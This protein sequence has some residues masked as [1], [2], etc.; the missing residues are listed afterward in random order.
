MRLGNYLRVFSALI[1]SLFWHSGASAEDYYWTLGG[2]SET[3][4]SAQQSCAS[5]FQTVSTN[6]NNAHESLY[7]FQLAISPAS[8]SG[9]QPR[10]LCAV[11][12]RL[13]TTT[14]QIIYS[15]SWSQTTIRNGS[16]C[17]DGTEYDS[18]TGECVAPEDPE[19]PC[20]DKAGVE[21]GFSKA[22]NAPDAFMNISSNGY[23]IPQRQGCK[24]GC[25]VE[26]TDLRCKTFIAGPYLCRGLMGFT[27]Q[28]CATTGT[29]T[30]VAEDVNDSVDPETV[31][32]DKPCVYTAD[33]DK[34][35]CESKK[36]EENTG[37][38][39]GTVNGVE[40]C[41]PKAPDKNGIDIR[42]EVTQNILEDGSTEIT[43]KDT[44]TVT[45]CKGIKTCTSTVTTT[46]T[47]TTKDANGNTTGTTSNCTGPSC[48]KGDSG[49][50]GDGN[51]G[52][53]L[54][55]ICAPGEESG[56]GGGN[57][58]PPELEDVPEYA[59]TVEGYFNRIKNA[60]I[61]ASITNLSVPSGGSCPT[62][63]ASHEYFGSVNTGVF[64]DMG[65][66][67]LGMLRYVFL[68]IWAWVAIRTFMTA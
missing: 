31:K 34:Q 66:D 55:G 4:P 47:T 22:G 59:D 20:A 43:K 50:E 27:G 16:T 40:T 1:F 44:A 51:S 56:S 9:G 63:S 32:E 65:P 52:I 54:S 60:P 57:V 68:A 38:S 15:G 25:A 26:I 6:P 11:K 30:E 18:T 5:F 21:E 45:S 46:T 19:D 49:G 24:E 12:R 58:T 2:S 42:T 61:I 17:S 36:S 3:F 7:D 13:I 29:G 41:V 10:F 28:Q 8:P 53:C 48:P 39:C 67:L 23:G 64:C 33:G 37:Q 35:V 14:G 62:Y